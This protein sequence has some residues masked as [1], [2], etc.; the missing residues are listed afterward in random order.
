MPGDHCDF[1]RALATCPAVQARA[2][3]VAKTDFEPVDGTLELPNPN[4][5]DDQGV[6]KILESAPLLRSWLNAVEG[7]AKD[8]LVQDANAFGGSY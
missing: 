1:C 6:L 3:E 5:L 4:T 8:R 7:W 2:K